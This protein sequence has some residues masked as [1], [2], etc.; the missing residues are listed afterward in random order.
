M[1]GYHYTTRQ[2]W[3][4]FIAHEGL[5]VAP[6][7][8]HE[9]ERFREDMPDCQE[10]GIWVWKQLLTPRQAWIVL[11]LLSVIHCDWDLVLLEVEYDEADT[12]VGQNPMPGDDTVKQTCNFSAHNLETGDLPIDII[13]EPVPVERIT[14]IWEHDLL[15]P[16][17]VEECY[18]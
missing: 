7:R 15:S 3:E 18:V 4:T 9:L 14:K 10:M 5:T 16:L 17:Q 1:R 2:V 11:A 13:V 12:M 8:A 6:I